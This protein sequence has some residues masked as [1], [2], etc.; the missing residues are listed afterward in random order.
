M[1]LLKSQSQ[2]GTSDNFT[3][4]LKAIRTPTREQIKSAEGLTALEA[5]RPYVAISFVPTTPNAVKDWWI[6]LTTIQLAVDDTSAG[7]S[8][9]E[10][11]SGRMYLGKG[12]IVID[13]PLTCITRFQIQCQ[14]IRGTN[15]PWTL[16]AELFDGSDAGAIVDAVNATRPVDVPAPKSSNP[17]ID[18]FEIFDSFN[19]VSS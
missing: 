15:N 12:R 7:T 10:D 9:L 16:I 13:A 18:L 6:Q 14:R 17:H 2:F 8:S 5:V 11:I 4:T 3:V 1:R 19:G